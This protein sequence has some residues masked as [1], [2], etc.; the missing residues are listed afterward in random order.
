MT[1]GLPIDFELFTRVHQKSDPEAPKPLLT[2]RYKEESFDL[3]MNAYLN[4]DQAEQ[5]ALLELAQQIFVS[6]PDVYSRWTRH[7]FQSA[8]SGRGEDVLRVIPESIRTY[9]QLDGNSDGLAIFAILLQAVVHWKKSDASEVEKLNLVL[10]QASFDEALEAKKGFIRGLKG[11]S[12]KLS[13]EQQ[14]LVMVLFF[15]ALQEGMDFSVSEF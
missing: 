2:D 11:A 4:A 7:F 14:E 5:E 12:E 9:L 3:V 15:S 13:A 6:T 10:H 1:I 8:V